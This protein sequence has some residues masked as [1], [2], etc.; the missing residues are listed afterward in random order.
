MNYDEINKF[1]QSFLDHIGEEMREDLKDTP[2]RLLSSFSQ[3]YSGYKSDPLSVLGD[4][5]L[6]CKAEEIIILKGLSFHSMCEHHLLPFFGT[7][8]LAYMSSGTTIGFSKISSLLSVLSKRL[9]IQERLNARFAEIIYDKLS[10]ISLVVSFEA[11]HL[12]M[13]MRGVGGDGVVKSVVEL[14][15]KVD[16]YKYLT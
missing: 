3:I 5:I 15:K 9:Q 8:S 16:L 12:C 10:P 6:E 13:H 4:E 11:R 2:A 7:V 1:F 14:G